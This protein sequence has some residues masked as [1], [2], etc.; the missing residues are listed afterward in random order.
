[1]LKRYLEDL[2]SRVDP[3][4]EEDVF[5]QWQRFWDRSIK[6]NFFVPIRPKIPSKLDWPPVNVNDAIEDKSF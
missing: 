6:D 3:V 5:A 4:V 1:M 2:E